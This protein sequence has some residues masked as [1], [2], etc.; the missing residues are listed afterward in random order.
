[1]KFVAKELRTRGVTVDDVVAGDFG[2]LC[3][4]KIAQAG[5]RGQLIPPLRKDIR[6]G[7]RIIYS[8]YSKI[9]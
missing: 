7:Q 2:V 5:R 3:F 9:I 1:M 4:Q 8:E 6:L